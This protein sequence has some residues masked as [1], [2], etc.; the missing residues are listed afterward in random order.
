MSKIIVPETQR[1][2]ILQGSVAL[3]AFEAG[4]FK[5]LYERI[6]S[7]DPN[8]EKRMFDIVAG[9]SA[10]AINASILI[11]HV[12]EKKTWKGSAEKLEEYWREHLSTPTP[13]AAK[14]GTQWWNETYQLWGGKYYEEW[15]NNN[16][17]SEEAARRYFSTKYFFTYGVPNV[18]SPSIP[19]P[20]PD[21]RF[22]DNNPLIPPA[23]LWTRYSNSPLRDSLEYQD[24]YKNKF[25]NFPLSTSFKEDEPRLLAISVDIQHGEPVTFDSYSN[26]STFQSYDPDSLSYKEHSIVYDKGIMSDHIMASASF[27]LYFDYQM[28][29]GRK[30]CDGGILSNTPLRELLQAHRDYWHKDIGADRVPNLEVYIIDVW[31]SVEAV[32]PSDQDGI[33]ERNNDITHSDK[34]EYDQKIAFLV[35]DYLNLFKKTKEIAKRHIKDQKEYEMFEKDVDGFLDTY[36]NNTKKRTGEQKKYSDLVN[37]RF[38]LK[39]VVTIERKDDVDS[40]SHKWA[41]YTSETIDKLISEGENFDKRAIVKITPPDLDII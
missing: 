23:N 36:T 34:T 28:I 6:K 11:S 1:A 39:R 38:D 13:D 37:G 19:F 21:Y 32:V 31:P 41:D 30:F 15:N 3:G 18:F 9:T 2:L 16:I 40:I 20:Q 26:K 22:F 35:T 5:N 29:D 24:R 10:G 7:K 27:P 33:K 4:V 25:V 14:F 8:W 12:K 17:A